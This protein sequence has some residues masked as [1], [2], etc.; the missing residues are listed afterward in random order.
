MNTRE[1]TIECMEKLLN[2]AKN[3][4]LFCITYDIS[5]PNNDI[6][7]YIIMHTDRT[8]WDGASLSPDTVRKNIEDGINRFRSGDGYNPSGISTFKMSQCMSAQDINF[9]DIYKLISGKMDGMPKNYTFLGNL[10]LL[11][12]NCASDEK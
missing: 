7:E 10:N 1:E 6:E 3:I 12:S 11:N 4:P 5:A 2:F 8:D 9:S